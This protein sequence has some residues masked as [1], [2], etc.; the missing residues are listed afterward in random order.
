MVD[1]EAAFLN[2]PVDTDV[3]I[4]MPEGLREY[5]L[6]KGKD[7]G[8]VVIKLKRAQYG[9]VQSPRLWMQTFSKILRGLGLTQAVRPTHVFSP[10]ILVLAN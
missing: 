2:A 3:F 6:S 1:V 8:D 4:E 5:F 7:V 10:F 9:L